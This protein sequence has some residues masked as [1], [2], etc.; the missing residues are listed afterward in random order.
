MIV[1]FRTLVAVFSLV[2]LL[3]SGA[4]FLTAGSSGV[5]DPP[6]RL[7]DGTEFQTWEDVTEYERVYYVD[8][9]HP[10][11]A[12]D[13]PGTE[14]A[15]FLTVQRAADMVRPAE[16]V[17]IKSGVYREW[18]RPRRGGTGP[19]GM[20]SFEAAPG[21]EAVI[22]GSEVLRAAWTNSGRSKS[23]NVWKADL[24][25][26]FFSDGHP[27]ATINTSDAD[28]SV[29][30][31]ARA[32]QGRIP[33]TLPRAMVFQDGRR[34]TQLARIEELHRVAGTFWIDGENRKLHLNPFDR[35]DP[36]TRQFEVT[37]RQ[38]LI[39]PLVKGMEY[40]R[41][42]GLTFEHAGNGFI[43]S[44]NGAITTW[45]GRHWI[46]EE[47]TVRHVNAVGI[48]IGAFTE[49]GPNAGNRNELAMTTGD[50][51]V[52]RNHVYDCGTGGIQGTVVSRSLVSDNHVHDCGWQDV[53]RYWEV[54]GIKLLIM[55]DSVVTRNHVHDCYASSGI[56]IDFANRNT[57]VTR[58]LIHDISS[59]AGGLFFEASNVV[60]LIDHNVVYNVQG[61]GFYLHDSDRLLVT[62]NLLVNCAPYG[63]RMTKTRTRDRV[64]V[65]KHN[66]VIN[67]VVAECPVPF[68]YAN[69]ENV[70]DYNIV[71]GAGRN[72][73]LAEWQSTGLDAHS[74]TADL[75]IAVGPE[76]G[77]LTWSARK[78]E[79]L[80][81]SRDERLGFDYFGRRY[82]DSVIAVGPFIEG[83]SRV[84]RRL[85]LVP[86]Q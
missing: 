73:S 22:S 24:P 82:P 49:E 61:S 37:T 32:E 39:N 41:I 20:I 10:A 30:H 68:E 83:W 65:S 77:V 8:Q 51:L 25:P 69:T 33:H 34:L 56:W 46:I 23:A 2:G 76:D 44:G 14:E 16:K 53:E 13:N 58:N 38:F 80:K 19:D 85:K 74:R 71:S 5:L 7:P 28:F 55:L 3:A 12:D 52:R 67:N 29:M 31:W 21:A 81:V 84:H 26:E 75:D 35:R 6:V 47:N 1:P 72:F 40:I 9:Q 15:P 18:V 60:N 36:N 70:S 43:R 50:H 27:F 57:R 62:H 64:G 45:G 11:A 54:A 66:R 79:V 48:E 59:Y 17:L 78:D 63:I 42:K 86:V 4:G